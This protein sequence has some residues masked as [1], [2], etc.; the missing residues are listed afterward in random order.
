MLSIK[1]AKYEYIA[2]RSNIDGIWGIFSTIKRIFQFRSN[3]WVVHSQAE[4]QG[5][6]LSQTEG[7]IY[8]SNIWDY[9]I[10]D[11]KLVNSRENFTLFR[12]SEK[13]VGALE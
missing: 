6:K 9:V 1:N 2:S 11:I 8:A 3:E 13:L 5:E 12:V 7:T 4:K 10:K